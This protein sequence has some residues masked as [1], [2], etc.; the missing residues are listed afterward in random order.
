MDELLEEDKLIV[1]CVCK[2]QCFLLQLFDVVKVFIGLDGVQVLLEDIIL[3]F[4]VV[5]NGEY[6]YLFEGVFYMV[7][8]IDEVFVKVEKMVV[9]VV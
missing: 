3:L 1:V 4:K 5:V 9:D 2:I 8:G 7:G 6:D